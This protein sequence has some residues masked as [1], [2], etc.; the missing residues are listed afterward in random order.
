MGDDDKTPRFGTKAIGVAQPVLLVED[1]PGA[2]ETMCDALEGAG[3][4]I[5]AVSNGR[6]ALDYLTSTAQQPFVVVL[7]LAMPVMDGWQLI[8]IMRSYRRLSM[9]PVV[10]VTAT[11]PAAES[12]QLF[13][14][15]LAKPFDPS[16]LIDAVARIAHG[17]GMLR[18]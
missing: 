7:D 6:E 18:R 5:V 17:D 8:A 15:F 13:E 10:V 1:D 2:R 3:Y 11:E 4:R 14:A 9:I 16:A 12:R